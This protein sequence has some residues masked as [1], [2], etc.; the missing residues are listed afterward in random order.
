MDKTKNIYKQAFK[1]TTGADI[2][3]AIEKLLNP[4]KP[5]VI[6]INSEILDPNHTNLVA[7]RIQVGIVTNNETKEESIIIGNLDNFCRNKQYT[8]KKSETPQ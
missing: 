2:L 5:I 6:C 8:L 3:L 4:E 1:P 7:N